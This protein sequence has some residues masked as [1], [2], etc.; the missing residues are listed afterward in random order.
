MIIPCLRLLP[1]CF[2]LTTHSRSLK[3][4]ESRFEGSKSTGW[5]IAG[6]AGNVSPNFVHLFKTSQ[7]YLRHNGGLVKPRTYPL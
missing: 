2:K 5:L 3:V 1:L 6:P 7:L 4:S